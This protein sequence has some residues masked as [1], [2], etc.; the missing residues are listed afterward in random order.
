MQ[1]YAGGSPYSSPEKAGMGNYATPI[2]RS[3]NDTLRDV[4]SSFDDSRS[5]ELLS[6]K[7]GRAKSEEP[8]DHNGT[9]NGDNDMEVEADALFSFASSGGSRPVKPLKRSGRKFAQTRSLPA[10]SLFSKESPLTAQPQHVDTHKMDEDWSAV[11][12]DSSTKPLELDI[13]F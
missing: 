3:A 1:G 8:E 11:A 12:F 10:W 2:F 9:E 5:P 4:Y 13:D 6:N 7:R